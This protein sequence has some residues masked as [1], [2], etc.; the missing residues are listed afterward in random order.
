MVTRAL[1]NGYGLRFLNKFGVREVS[2]ILA[3]DKRVR[4]VSLVPTQLKRLLDLTDFGVHE[5]FKTILLGG[6]PVSYEIIQRCKERGIPVMTSF[7]MTET[8]AQCISVPFGEVSPVVVKNNESASYSAQ[9]KG[10][11]DKYFVSAGKP[12][13]GMFVDLRPDTDFDPET[14]SD[15]KSDNVS[16]PKL[17]WIKGNQVFDGYLSLSESGSIAE[18]IDTS[19]FD[20]EGWFCTGDYAFSDKNGHI[21]IEMRRT[22]RIVSGGKNV[23]P[24]EIEEVLSSLLYLKDVAVYG[25]D[26][27]EWGQVVCAAVVLSDSADEHLPSKNAAEELLELIKKDTRS[28]LPSYKIPKK[29]V[30]LDSIPRTSSGKLKRYLL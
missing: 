10:F 24:T 13:P 11:I 28:K 12:L 8:A 25:K 9:N 1:I 16:A 2:D 19:D 29:V 27:N 15:S 4:G 14:L 21:Y 6:G 18:K 20:K 5:E 26:D 3:H 17:L 7:G 23:N 22:D 30:I